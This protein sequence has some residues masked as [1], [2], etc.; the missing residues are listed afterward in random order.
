MWS[1]KQIETTRKI[2]FGSQ[3]AWKNIIQYQVLL[4]KTC[5]LVIPSSNKTSKLPLV[6]TKIDGTS[7]GNEPPWFTAR[8]IIQSKKSVLLKRNFLVIIYTAVIWPF[9]SPIVQMQR[10]HSKTLFIYALSLFKFIKMYVISSFE[11]DSLETCSA[12]ELVENFQ[13]ASV[14]LANRRH[15]NFYLKSFSVLPSTLVLQHKAST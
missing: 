11:K 4:N 15:S 9:L 8:N 1:I 7:Y 5:L 10:L 14:L 2:N 3:N 12:K 6:A 13:Y